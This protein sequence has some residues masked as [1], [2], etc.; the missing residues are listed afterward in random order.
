MLGVLVDWHSARRAAGNLC[1]YQEL[2][3]HR[4]TQV[5][6]QHKP[7]ERDGEIYEAH[8]PLTPNTR[9]SRLVVVESDSAGINNDN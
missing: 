5:D 7:F 3:P 9:D 6:A 4:P 8:T 2:G 1:L